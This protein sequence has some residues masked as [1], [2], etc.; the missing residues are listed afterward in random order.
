[1]FCNQDE[2]KYNEGQQQQEIIIN[3]N[4]D[5]VKITTQK[6][7]VSMIVYVIIDYDYIE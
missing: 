3:P 6:S 5:T 7:D 4:W 2:I 1:M